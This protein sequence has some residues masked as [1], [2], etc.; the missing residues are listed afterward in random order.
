MPATH[1]ALIAAMLAI[2]QAHK[3][4]PVSLAQPVKGS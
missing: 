3:P 1:K 2:V 4:A